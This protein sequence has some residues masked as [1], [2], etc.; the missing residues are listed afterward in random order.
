MNWAQFKYPVSHM[1]L[2]G[3]VVACWFVTQEVAGSNTHF[4]QRYFSSSANSVDSTEFIQEKL[5]CPRVIRDTGCGFRT[6]YFPPLY[7]SIKLGTGWVRNVLLPTALHI[8]ANICLKHQA[9]LYRSLNRWILNRKAHENNF[10][11]LL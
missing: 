2:A 10:E 1:C 8:N 3:A 6:S 9:F 4:L 11:R 5:Y 7:D